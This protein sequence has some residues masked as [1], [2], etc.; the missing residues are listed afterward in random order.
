MTKICFSCP[1]ST[2]LELI[3]FI[4]NQT[5]TK[6]VVAT[7][8]ELERLCE[9]KR[10]GSCSRFEYVILV[11]GVISEAAKMAEEAN[12]KVLSFAK[13]EAIGAQTIATNGH[14]HRPPSGKDIFTF[15]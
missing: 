9:V 12:L 4:L 10:S 7:R 2:A 15:C 5:G 13:V 6:S 11:D 8:A 3:I 14:K 1:A